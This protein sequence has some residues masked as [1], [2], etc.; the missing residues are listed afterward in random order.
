MRTGFHLQ[1]SLN[2]NSGVPNPLRPSPLNLL[3][4][5]SL[6]VG[7]RN[8]IPPVL[9]PQRLSILGIPPIP[10]LKERLFPF[11]EPR[12]DL[13]P[14][15][16]PLPSPTCSDHS[17]CVTRNNSPAHSLVG[18][19]DSSPSDPSSLVAPRFLLVRPRRPPSLTSPIHKLAAMPAAGPGV[20]GPRRPAPAVVRRAPTATEHALPT[21]S[22]HAPKLGA[23]GRA[24][25]SRSGFFRRFGWK[26][27]FRFP[28]GGVQTRVHGVVQG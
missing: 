22:A 15:T 5:G 25:V 10:V 3:P 12:R 19:M 1:S 11:H 6:P 23:P 17:S 4:L 24:R 7:F 26:P 21:P 8:S 27:N 13:S 28:A 9:E 2:P 20:S 14:V 16:E 18:S